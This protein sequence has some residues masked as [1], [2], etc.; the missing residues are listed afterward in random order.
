MKAIKRNTA[1]KCVL[2]A[3]ILIAG[4]TCLI[5]GI[6]RMNRVSRQQLR[7][8]AELNAISYADRMIGDIREGINITDALEQILISEDGRLDRF[9]VV[10][11]DLMT[12]Y[13]QSIQLAQG[14]VVTEI[15]PYEGN[16]AGKID[17]INDEK[18][19][20]ITR[21]GRDNDVIVMQG[22]FTL[23]Q[24][25]AGLAIRNP[26]Y[27]DDDNRGR[28]FWGFTI[29]IIRVPD[30]FADSIEAL[31][32]FGY[33]YRL[34]KTSS[35]LDTEYVEIYSSGKELIN[36]VVYEFALGECSWRLEVMPSAGWKNKSYQTEIFIF[37]FIIVL[38]LTG[39]T[40]ALIIIEE[41]RNILKSISVTDGL[42]GIL[43][44]KG[45]DE[46]VERYMKKNPQEH[47]VCIE[48]D[49][50]DF[51]FIN[52]IYGH[53]TGDK[54]LKLVAESMGQVFDNNAI[55]GRNGG[56]EFCI[57]V[58]NCTCRDI[59]EKIQ[60]FTD[61]KREF[62]HEGSVH[63]FS[64]SVGYAEY[65]VHAKTR[66]ELMRNADMALYAV[67]LQ[68]KKGCLEYEESFR[69]QKRSRLGFAL[70]DVSENLP[71]AF[72]IYKADK[73]DDRILFANEEMITFAGCTDME[74]FMDYTGGSFRNLIKEQERERTEN[75]IWEQ[76]KG[77]SG[78]RVDDY[79]CFSLVKKDGICRTVYDHGRIV[80]NRYYGKVF[81]VFIIDK[82]NLSK[83]NQF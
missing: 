60:R 22:P 81:Y 25:G 80:E 4:I 39:L 74:D 7:A 69:I 36:P 42:T 3:L 1:Y 76:L 13:V 54:A 14:G 41:R 61:M 67:K 52:D 21:Y 46:Q 44:R 48:F 64:I 20:P 2:A 30:I 66:T 24:G 62:E 79:A 34:S 32:S 65:P 50:D 5:M 23:N 45:F 49:I 35:P 31:G 43:N 51:K 18:R 29:V 10:A 28:D 59:E 37:G 78:D 9:D 38:L 17:L 40:I 8:K 15:Y 47:S 70:R 73:N 26:V 83:Y 27:L 72:M 55:L 56:D 63:T 68:G 12:D 82:D 53:S 16:E 33:E 6:W 11:D 71:C 77:A 57:F 58:K 19:G 75:I